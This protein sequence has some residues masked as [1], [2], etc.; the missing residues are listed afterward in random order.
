MSTRRA[1]LREAW[2]ATRTIEQLTS[3]EVRWV[4]RSCQLL[5]LRM[6]LWSGNRLGQTSAT[7]TFW[8]IYI[9]SIKPSQGASERSSQPIPLMMTRPEASARSSSGESEVDATQCM[10]LNVRS[11]NFLGHCSS[12]SSKKS[13]AS[14]Y[15]TREIRRRLRSLTS[16]TEDKGSQSESPPCLCLSCEYRNFCN[17]SS[18]AYDYHIRPEPASSVYMSRWDKKW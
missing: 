7:T 15:R 1:P 16:R 14:G 18:Y 13:S 12:T 2:S 6:S 17:S 3:M 8:A 4:N 9:D 11:I 5:T 10:S